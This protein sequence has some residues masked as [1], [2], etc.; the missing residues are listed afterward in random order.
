MLNWF[1]K[2]QGVD[3]YEDKPEVEEEK[4]VR[5]SEVTFRTGATRLKRAK[6]IDSIRQSNFQL[7]AANFSPSDGTAMDD[8]TSVAFSGIKSAYAFRGMNITDNQLAY[9]GSQ[10]FIGYQIMA[11]LSQNWLINKACLQPAEDAVRNGFN[12]T[13][14]DGTE[15]DPEVIKYLEKRNKAYGLTEALKNYVYYGRMFGI[16]IVMFDVESADPEYYEKPFNIDGVTPGSYKGMSQI[17]PYWI[18]PELSMRASSDP[19]AQRFYEPTWWRVN[20]KRVHWSHLV[21][22]KGA[23]VADVLKPT[24]LYGGLSIPQLIFERVYAAER[25]ANEAPMLAQSKRETVIH[26]DMDKAM[27]NEAALTEKLSWWSELRNNWGIKVLGLEETMEQ[28]DTSLAD[29]DDVIMTQ[30]QLVAS[31]A[32]MPV[33]KLLGMV[34]KGFNATGEYDEASYHEGLE[35]VQA[36]KMTP[37]VDR[38][39]QLVI[40]SDIA[41][42]F[43]IKPF[44]V[45]VDWKTLDTM[46]AKEEADIAKTKAET[47]QVLINSGA[48]DGADERARI[49]ADPT[50]GYDG[51]PDAE[52]ELPIDEE[53]PV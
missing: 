47:G 9:F 41:P 32:G 29:F 15:L 28:Y 19:S 46:T 40:K 44:S 6:L 20:G 4:E 27:A 12:L 30:Y 14:N 51:L 48:I 2:K 24:Y 21:I 42:K 25:T 50:S 16:R 7:T 5:D 31:I 11:I 22:Y 37:L 52:P 49:V 43:G 13:V 34:P 26:V 17:D 35:T 8:A 23:E 45:E 33:T 1:R 39:N 3:T 53:P 36:H 10:G 38:H 18:T